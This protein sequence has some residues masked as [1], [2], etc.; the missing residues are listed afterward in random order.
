MQLRR[1][2]R[3]LAGPRVIRAFEEVYPEAFFIEIG[4]N[5]GDNHDHLQS[6][7]VSGSWRG[8]MVEPVPYVFARLA[9]NYGS[10]A[11]RIA[12]ENAA[13]ADRDGQLPFYHPA[14]PAPE[15]RE[16]LPDWYDE[17]GSFSRET[18]LGHADEIPDIE[19]RLVESQV[20]CLTFGSLC[21]KHDI[22][23]FDLL[24]IDTEGYDHEILR[25]VDF[26]VYRP[27]LVV[28]EHFHMS[29]PDRAQTR[30]ALERSGY[31]TFEEGFDTWCLD[32]S[33]DDRLT[34]VWRNT[35][36]AVP[37]LSALDPA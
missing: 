10:L 28:Y 1:I 31:E 13:I 12:L 11:D 35:R 7:I 5:A 24:V 6:T 25:G 14:E 29:P 32:P 21:A 9:E 8:L 19:R 27:R 18:V 33:R 30:A 34:S 36:P 17:I 23:E 16:T 37:G 22:E 15:E 3:R 26:D 4:A 20:H 2:Q